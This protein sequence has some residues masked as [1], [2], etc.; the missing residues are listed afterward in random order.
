MRHG[1]GR[2]GRAGEQPLRPLSAS[3]AAASAAALPVPTPGLWSG[4]GRPRCRGSSARVAGASDSEH[5]PACHGAHLSSS[6]VTRAV[7][8]RLR[9]GLR[10]G[11][12]DAPAAAVARSVAGHVLWRCSSLL[13]RRGRGAR[14]SPGRDCSPSTAARA[15]SEVPWQTCG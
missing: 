10:V 1:P 14:A 3:G 8:L 4:P 15:A 12:S 5:L 7:T 6:T 11:D 13:F 9:P 2:R